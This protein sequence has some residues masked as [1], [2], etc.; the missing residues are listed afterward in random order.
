MRYSRLLSL[1]ISYFFAYLIFAGRDFGPIHNLILSIGISGALISGFFYAFG[2]TAAPAAAVLL[3]TAESQ[4]LI[5]TGLVAGLGALIG[6]LGI[7]FFLKDF[8]AQDL[9]QLSQT[10]FARFIRRE[11]RMI[12][13]HW[14]K[15]LSLAIAGL[16]I[17]SP[18]PTEV[19]VAI[20][21]SLR[22]MPTRT[23]ALLTF[24]LHTLGIFTILGIGKLSQ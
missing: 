22:R 12:L 15:Y 7:F 3:V 4:D 20:L 2:F 18:L 24:A 6:D 19:G 14:Q 5:L 10:Q 9:T 13:G 16:F 21:S 8:F 1:A 11:E 17:A 23:F